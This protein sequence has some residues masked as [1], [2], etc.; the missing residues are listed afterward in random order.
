MR[1]VKAIQKGLFDNDQKWSQSAYNI[2]TKDTQQCL[3]VTLDNQKDL[4]LLCA[5]RFM[6]IAMYLFCISIN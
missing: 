6:Y 5:Y 3:N 4:I 1:G 2:I